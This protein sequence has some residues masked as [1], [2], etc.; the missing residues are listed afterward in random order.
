MKRGLGSI[1]LIASIAWLAAITACGKATERERVDFE[2]MRI[3]QRADL[4]DPS[5]IFPSGG[6]MQAPPTGTVSRESAA[7]SGVVGSGM[8]GKALAT[9]IPIA[10]TPALLDSGKRAF[11]TY[12]AVCHGPAAFGGSLVASNMGPPRPPSLR[13]PAMLAQPIGYIYYIATNGFGRMPPYN[14]QLTARQRWAVAAYVQRLQ[15]TPATD[16]ISITD[17]LNALTYAR[18]DSIA[19]S[20]GQ[21][22]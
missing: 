21:Q 18:W 17:S 11:T 4:Y 7:D 20:R 5:H 9:T 6:V 1:A 13:R 2:R 10:I 22:P 15:H 3:Q 14:W 16:S 8:N 19:A 12:C